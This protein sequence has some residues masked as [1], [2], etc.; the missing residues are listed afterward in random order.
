M[1]TTLDGTM[2][3]I[4]EGRPVSERQGPPLSRRDP[5]DA[6]LGLVGGAGRRPRAG[7]PLTA[8]FIT[9]RPNRIKGHWL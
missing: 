1:V 9:V 4:S 7:V 8:V 5:E 6:I 3:V 2:S